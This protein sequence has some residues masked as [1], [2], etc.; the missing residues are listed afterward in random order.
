MNRPFTR[1]PAATASLRF[2][3]ACE[4]RSGRAFVLSA[5]AVMLALALTI[6]SSSFAQT[7]FGGPTH[8]GVA[9][10]LSYA[11]ELPEGTLVGDCLT[12]PRPTA[13]DYEV[14]FEAD[15]VP[16]IFVLYAVL[17]D[18]EP[19]DLA[20]ATFGIEYSET[21]ELKGWGYCHG[22]GVVIPTPEYPASGAGIALSFRPRY[23]ESPAPIAWF[24]L[25]S[26]ED[27]YFA[28]EPHP[29]PRQAARVGNFDA[30]PHLE[31]VVG[32]GRIGFGN[33]QGH[34]PEVGQDVK[35]GVCCLDEC[36]L[37]TE[38]ECA[39]YAGLFL[40]EGVCDP[41]VCTAETPGACCVAEGCEVLTRA[42]CYSA[43]GEFL[44]EGVTCTPDVCADRDS[45]K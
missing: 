15:G 8:E 16:R 25:S 12:F 40:G 43:V 21:V 34:V 38:F 11:S 6:P 24:V 22:N 31:P 32:F 37:L 42:Q 17:P 7:Q 3:R 29:I 14:S 30:K 35:R 19:M 45:S 2:V 10:V 28:V 18:G 27:G 26:K 20:G 36:L 4:L 33:E 23:E 5:A 41:G 13:G 44:G 9:Y 39:H 1:H